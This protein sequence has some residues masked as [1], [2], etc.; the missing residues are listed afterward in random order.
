MVVFTSCK[1][2][3]GLNII[4]RRTDGYHDISTIMVP[5]DWSDILEIVRRLSARKE[6]R[7]ESL[8]RSRCNN[9]TPS[10]RHIP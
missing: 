3:L 7:Y 8:P 6:S 4:A 9:A 10:C 5:V 2:N 1:I